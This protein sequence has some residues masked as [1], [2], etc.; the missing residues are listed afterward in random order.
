MRHEPGS[1][2]SWLAYAKSDLALAKHADDPGVLL[3]TL[4]FHAQ[5]AAEKSIKAVLIRYGIPAPKTHSIER[6]V[7]MLP[8]SVERSPLLV[9]AAQL[10]EYAVT[11]RYPGDEPP[12][13]AE[14][15]GDAV[16]LAEA[17]VLWAEGIVG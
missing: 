3:E 10:S 6:L 13:S 4:C 16:R 7:D 2:G 17:V 12:V 5:Q 1:P 9:E 8:P 14:E 15:Y 11:F